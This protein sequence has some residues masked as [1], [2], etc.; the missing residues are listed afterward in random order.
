MVLAATNSGMF[1]PKR[2]GLT[3]TPSRA[4]CPP[5]RRSAVP[6]VRRGGAERAEF[7]FPSPNASLARRRSW[8]LS[9]TEKRF[10]A[11]FPPFA[12]YR[13]ESGLFFPP[14]PEEQLIPNTTP[15]LTS[16]M[17]R[18]RIVVR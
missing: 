13:S 18:C 16:T 9:P 5:C 10:L 12:A 4:E 17:R 8:P 2:R 15:A 7:I 6:K 14:K 3:P 1:R 11:S